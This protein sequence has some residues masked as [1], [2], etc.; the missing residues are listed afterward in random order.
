M[1]VLKGAP[2]GILG[3]AGSHIY[4]VFHQIMKD[5]FS[6]E[7]CLIKWQMP[8]ILAKHSS[9]SFTT[10]I[11]YIILSGKGAILIVG[12]FVY[13]DSENT[14]EHSTVQEQSP[15]TRI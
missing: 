15:G 14:A 9:L 12:S 3:T 1:W 11:F 13:V 5:F 2:C 10:L 7:I 4:Q 8:C 6:E